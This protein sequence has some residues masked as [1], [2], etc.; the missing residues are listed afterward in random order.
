ME[1]FTDI[2]LFSDKT[3]AV[4]DPPAVDPQYSS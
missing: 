2:G 4:K 3:L 1:T